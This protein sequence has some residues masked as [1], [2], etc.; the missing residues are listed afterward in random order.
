MPWHDDHKHTHEQ[1]SSKHKHEAHL[2][3]ELIAGAAAYEVDLRC[4]AAKAYQAHQAKNGKH[5]SHE[6]AKSF[7]VALAAAFIDKEFETKGLDFLD[8]QKVKHDAQKHV[9]EGLNKYGGYGY[10]STNY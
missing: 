10:T 1:Y 8:K 9:E 7:A 3:H 2:S 5:T 6:Q 4:L